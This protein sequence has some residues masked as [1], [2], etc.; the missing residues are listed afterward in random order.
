MDFTSAEIN[1]LL[2]LTTDLR[3]QKHASGETP[4]LAG[5]NI[6]LIFEKDS[7]CT[8]CSFEVAAFG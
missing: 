6:A 7:T 4:R 1:Q 2:T 8:R 3:R 5:K